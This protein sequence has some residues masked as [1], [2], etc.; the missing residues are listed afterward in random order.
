MQRKI[1]TVILIY[2][3][4]KPMEEKRKLRL[5]PLFKKAKMRYLESRAHYKLCQKLTGL[6]ETKNHC[7][8]YTIKECDGACIGTIP[9]E[10]YNARVQEFID[11]NVFEKQ[12]HRHH[13]PRKNHQ[14]ALGSIDREWHLQ[15]LR[16]LRFE[17]PNPKHRNP[18][19]YVDTHGKQSRYE[20]QL[21]KFKFEEV[22]V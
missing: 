11:K 18:K 6:Y 13:K 22:E 4:K 1:Q 15:R 20:N 8:Q 2:T 3:F 21:L 9:P 17:L 19:E 12:N 5:S 14:R 10:E 7:F 16:I